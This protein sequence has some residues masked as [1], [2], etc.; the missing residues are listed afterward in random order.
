MQMLESLQDSH[1]G[2]GEQRLFGLTGRVGRI[3]ARK[4]STERLDGGAC[5]G[6]LVEGDLTS[7]RLRRHEAKR[8]HHS[9]ARLVSSQSFSTD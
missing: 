5:V 2:G 3:T 9:T 4:A 7:V 8:S 1:G 6:D